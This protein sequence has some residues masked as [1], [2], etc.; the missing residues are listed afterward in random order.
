MRLGS[1]LLLFLLCSASALGLGISQDYHINNTIVVPATTTYVQ[2]V[3]IQ[4][5]LPEA[6]IINFTVSGEYAS[7]RGERE[8]LVTVPANSINTI[9]PITIDIPADAVPGTTIRVTYTVQPMVNESGMVNMA[10][11]LRDDFTVRVAGIPPKKPWLLY[12]AIALVAAAILF[13]LA[14]F[15]YRRVRAYLAA[16]VPRG[17]LVIGS[18]YVTNTQQLAE[19]VGAMTDTQFGKLDK[20]AVVQWVHAKNRDPEQYHRLKLSRTR[21]DFLRGLR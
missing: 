10:V 4:N 14:L 9:V 15:V 12:T 18:S 8:A 1:F 11:R 7:V 20:S 3:T 21:A 2:N 13:F 5:N 6:L 19:R 17:A 16:R